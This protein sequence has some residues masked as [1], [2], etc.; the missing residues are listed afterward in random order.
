MDVA[1]KRRRGR[2]P[3]PTQRGKRY[4]L[5]IRVTA[6]VKEVIQAAAIASGR[7]QA[8]EVELRLEWSATLQDRLDRIEASIKAIGALLYATHGE[9]RG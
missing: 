2:P 6:E 1:E 8:Q 4:P 3:L 9:H 5:G 7:S